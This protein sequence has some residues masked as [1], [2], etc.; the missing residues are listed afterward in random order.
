MISAVEGVKADTERISLTGGVN[1]ISRRTICL[2]SP[3]N[4]DRP[5]RGSYVDQG[6]FF[7]AN[8]EYSKKVKP[9]TLRL[10]LFIRNRICSFSSMPVAF[11]PGSKD[12]VERVAHLIIVNFWFFHNLSLFLSDM[13]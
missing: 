2:R 1:R 6:M 10:S 4:S 9:I 11:V 3:D 7:W 5:V 8:R 13:L 12:T